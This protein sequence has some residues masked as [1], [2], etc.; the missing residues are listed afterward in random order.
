MSVASVA[1][2]GQIRCSDQGVVDT[3]RYMIGHQ[4]YIGLIVEALVDGDLVEADLFEEDLFK[5]A[6]YRYSDF[7]VENIATLGI[8]GFS[9][10]CTADFNGRTEEYMVTPVDN[11][12][13]FRMTSA[14]RL[15]R[16]RDDVVGPVDLVELQ[17]IIDQKFQE[18][19]IKIR[20]IEKA[21]SHQQLRVVG[22][23]GGAGIRVQ[24]GEVIDQSHPRESPDP[25]HQDKQEF[26]EFNLDE[27]SKLLNKKDP[28]GGG[29]PVPATE[30]Q[31]LGS[32]DGRADAAMTQSEIEALKARLYQCWNPPVAA[33]EAGTLVVQ[34]RITLLPDGSLSGQPTIT[35]VAH[36]SRFVSA[37]GCGGGNPRSGRMRA[38]R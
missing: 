18:T 2:A 31:T 24:P 22:E 23:G 7:K 33:R 34:V 3:F 17:K 27:I 26:K 16:G 8:N 35:A 32:V 36:A 28:A 25:V 38:V 10:Y 37:G 13:G 5:A 30:P 11:G 1:Q 19:R 12:E 4:G 9:L 15:S 6:S 29:D 14:Y 21:E 20:E